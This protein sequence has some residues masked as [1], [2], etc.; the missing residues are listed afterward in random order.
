MPPR[1]RP[2]PSSC[3]APPPP[4]PPP[5]L[6]PAMFQ[7][8]VVA[9]VA[10]AMSQIGTNGNGGSGSGAT[11]SNQGDSSGRTKECTYKYFTNGKPN[12]FNG[13]GGIITLMQ[14]FERTEAV[15]EIYACPETSKVKYATLT[16]TGRALTWCNDRVKS[17]TL[18]V[19]NSISWEDLKSLMLK[20][21]CP[22]A[23]LCPTMVTLEE[24]K[25]ERYLWGLSSQIQDTVL[26]LKPATFEISKELAQQ[27]ID[28]RASRGTMSATTDQ[29]K[30]GNNTR[31][32]W[33]NKKKQPAQ[34]PAKKQ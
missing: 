18:V 14:W 29:A 22:R 9:A 15:F 20:E 34:D 28:H 31:M 21:Y 12:T 4:P 2:R 13:S 10:A 11:P 33:N 32:F 30:G 5:Q 8:A 7:A 24:K 19:A 1:K 17:P 27:L 16:F 6:D 23:L 25:V 3:A 26:A